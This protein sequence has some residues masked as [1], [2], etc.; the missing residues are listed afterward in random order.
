MKFGLKIVIWAFNILKG[1]S[2]NSCPKS[3]QHTKGISCNCLKYKPLRIAYLQIWP[4]LK[5]KMQF[6]HSSAAKANILTVLDQHAT[7]K[8]KM[9]QIFYVIFLR[10]EKKEKIVSFLHNTTNIFKNM[11]NLC[12]LYLEYFFFLNVSPFTWFCR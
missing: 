4:Q 11:P 3:A 8:Y 2:R 9:G 6:D 1:I 10:V 12:C 5:K 7:E